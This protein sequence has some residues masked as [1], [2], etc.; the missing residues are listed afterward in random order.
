MSG[1]TGNSRFFL[2]CRWFS[3]LEDVS[4]SYGSRT[5]ADDLTQACAA[6]FTAGQPCCRALPPRTAFQPCAI[7]SLEVGGLTWGTVTRQIVVLGAQPVLLGEC[8]LPTR[9]APCLHRLV[10]A[11][12]WAAS[13]HAS[14]SEAASAGRLKK[15]LENPPPT[16]LDCIVHRN[17]QSFRFGPFQLCGHLDP[18][19]DL[20]LRRRT[21]LRRFFA[22]PLTAC[23]CRA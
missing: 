6:P 7:R 5:G 16:D 22:A 10:S 2:D 23:V 19:V 14:L 15:R 4:G 13:P 9:P 12:S 3:L 21:G 18:R 11:D 1:T 17:T 20:A 8:L